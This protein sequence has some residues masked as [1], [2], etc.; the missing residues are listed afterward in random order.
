MSCDQSIYWSYA[1]STHSPEILLRRYYL[2]GNIMWA[3]DFHYVNKAIFKNPG[4][5]FSSSSLQL[6]VCGTGL[7]AATT[8][9]ELYYNYPDSS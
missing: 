2:L 3:N 1:V 6:L 7:G 5:L 4:W 9:S 8:G